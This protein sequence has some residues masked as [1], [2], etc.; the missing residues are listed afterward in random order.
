MV[1]DGVHVQQGLR[2]MRMAAVAGVDDMDMGRH[3][4]RDQVRRAAGAVAHHEQVGLHGRQVGDGIE[5]GFALG[6]GRGGDVQVDH[7]GRQALGGDL[8]GGARA[9]G[10]L[11]E[12]VEHAFAVQQGQLG[13][14]LSGRRHEGGGQVEDLLDD[15][16]RQAFGGQQVDQLAVAIE[17]GIEHGQRQVRAATGYPGNV[18]I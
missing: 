10:V 8:E 6:R 5:Q 13:E 7:V 14:F 1:T 9:G 17:L 3:V 4:L 18:A 12:Q 16:A 2:G 11:E 15:A